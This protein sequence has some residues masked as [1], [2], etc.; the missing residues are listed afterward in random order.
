M[1]DLPLKLRNFQGIIEGD[2][3]KI[4][5]RYSTQNEKASRLNKQDAFKELLLLICSLSFVFFQ[6]DFTHT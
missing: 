5:N 2:V 4:I 1:Y 6:E 3:L